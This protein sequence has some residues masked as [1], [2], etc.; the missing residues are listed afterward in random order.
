MGRSRSPEGLKGKLL[1]RFAVDYARTLIGIARSLSGNADT[2]EIARTL[3]RTLIRVYLEHHHVVQGD[4]SFG[5]VEF[6]LLQLFP[7]MEGRSVDGIGVGDIIDAS[8][9][10]AEL[11][12]ALGSYDNLTSGFMGAGQSGQQTLTALLVRKPDRDKPLRAPI[13]ILARKQS[14]AGSLVRAYSGADVVVDLKNRLMYALGFRRK[15]EVILTG[16]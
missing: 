12:T 1:A 9:T 15:G 5:A 14:T 4:P 7:D 8:H 6:T 3:Y 11:E 13:E 10:M 16:P 2:T